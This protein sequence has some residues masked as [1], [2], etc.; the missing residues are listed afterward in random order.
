MNHAL[1]M[2][3]LYGYLTAVEAA[4]SALK[5]AG[6]SLVDIVKVKGGL[7]TVF[8]KGDV[9]AVKAAMDA[10]AAAAERVGKVIS[11]HVIPRPADGAW[12]L[13]EHKNPHDTYPASDVNSESDVSLESD[14]DSTFA[15]D[16]TVAS[17]TDAAYKTKTEDKSETY[18]QESLNAMTVQ[19]LRSLARDLNITSIDRSQLRFAKKRELVDAILN[20]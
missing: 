16:T 1:G 15:A 3:E 11:V 9:G 18:T 7:V 8:V 12:D 4:D 10:A 5:A 19:K 17:D 14:A 20:R 13:I 2:I 6:V